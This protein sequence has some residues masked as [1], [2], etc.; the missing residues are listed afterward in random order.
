MLITDGLSNTGL[1]RNETL[2][3]LDNIV[4]PQGCVFNT[5]GFGEDHDSKLLSAIALRTQ[6]VYYF[7]PSIE[8]IHKIFGGCVLAVL[9]FR[10][11]K[12]KL[13]IT[14]D[15]GSRIISLSTPFKIT[16]KNVA[17]NYEI[18]V[19]L[20]YSGEYKSIIFRLSLRKMSQSM[21]IH[22]LLKVNVEFVDIISGSTDSISTQLF[23]ERNNINFPEKIPLLLD[24][25][26]NRYLAARTIFE[27]I[28]LG[29]RLQFSEAQLKISEC[30]NNIRSSVSGHENYCNLLIEDLEDCKIGLSDFTSFQTGAHS[31]H[32]Y[33]S[34][35]YMERSSGV[36][37]RK[38]KKTN[39]IDHNLYGY[40]TNYIIEGQEQFDENSSKN[41]TNYL[42]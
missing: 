17:K 27:A 9:S 11:R 37:L 4:L 36:E 42:F 6:G 35:Y 40:L 32:A 22:N 39:H 14:A 29:N 25:N 41:L 18:D 13:N 8:Y 10:T 2:D 33:A 16:E 28:E 30:I 12:V 26:L 31:A 23:V 21:D 3:R 19:G 24:Q 7:V 38:Y 15:D 34:M 5:F 1:S 20:M